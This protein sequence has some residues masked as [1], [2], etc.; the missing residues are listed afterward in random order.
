MRAPVNPLLR[1]C[2]GLAA[3]LA[4]PAPGQA[5]E[6]APLIGEN[7]WVPSLSASS[8]VVGDEQSAA[9]SSYDINEF[10]PQF[11]D[12]LRPAESKDEVAVTPYVSAAL[13]LMTP[14]LP[15][16]PLRPRIFFEGEID[17]M[18]A[19]DRR[20]AGEGDATGPEPPPNF[21]P[22]NQYQYTQLTGLGSRTRTEVETLAYGAELGL[23][24][25]FEL[26]GRAL[27]IKPS[28]GWLRF[29]VDME[30]RVVDAKCKN[31]NL[32]CNPNAAIPG[33][34]GQMGF[35]RSIDMRGNDTQS[36]DAIGPGLELEMDAGRLG[37]LALSIFLGGNAYRIL[38]NRK[39][40]DSTQISILDE[41][42]PP[43]IFGPPVPEIYR[44]NW[45]SEVD[46]W[47]YRGGL[48]I[49]LHWVGWPD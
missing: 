9:V 21:N 47:L 26:F 16:V 18:F 48:G 22:A 38:G 36:F 17:P 40:E 7:L 42:T 30:G 34:P 37:P 28:A 25:P 49:R 15:Y 39:L 1:F 32:S 3:L 8:G 12:P 44:A 24:F 46:E 23:A 43:P 10:A 31:N 33:M 6:E 27:R 11:A 14:A 19:T 4:L 35:T 41:I 29:S 5:G 13:Q 20:I 2:A 45:S